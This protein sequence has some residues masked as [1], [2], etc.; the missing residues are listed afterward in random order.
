MAEAR[1]FKRIER[2]LVSGPPPTTS[3]ATSERMARVRQRGT[4]AELSVRKVATEMGLRYRTHNRDLPGSPDLA[5]RTRKWAVF[6]HGCFWHQHAGCPAATMPKSNCSFWRAK[7]NANRERDAR[8]KSALQAQGF[9]VVVVWEC[10]ARLPSIVR[11]ALAV[12][13]SA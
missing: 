11:E 7:F 4:V 6:V 8:V 9:S 12:L 2:R 10:Q 1:S 5:N 13:E 3:A